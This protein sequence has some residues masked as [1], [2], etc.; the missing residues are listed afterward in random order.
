MRFRIKDDIEYDFARLCAGTL[1]EKEERALLDQIATDKPTQERWIEFCGNFTEQELLTNFH[2]IDNPT[3]WKPFTPE[4]IDTPV[5]ELTTHKKSIRWLPYI[6]YA[7]AI[8][9]S[10][11]AIKNLPRLFTPDKTSIISL[12]DSHVNPKGVVLKLA[13]GQEIDLSKSTQ[14]IALKDVQVA[15][16]D[17]I[18]SFTG[19]QSGTNTLNV[20]AGK[21]ISIK[22]NDGSLLQVNSGTTV[23]FPFTFGQSREISVTG[24]AYLNI[25]K[26][27]RRPF[28]VHTPG[29]DVQVLGTEFNLNSYDEKHTKVSLIKGS[30][31]V[32]TQTSKLV[33]KPG[34]TATINPDA[35][36]TTE[37]SQNEVVLGWKKGNYSFKN[38]DLT[39]IKTVL[40]RWYG[41]SVSIDNPKLLEQKFTGGIDKNADITVFLNNLAAVTTIKY[42]LDANTVRFN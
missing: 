19:A 24:E 14:S 13:D 10:I 26:D 8:C 28:V 38:A 35:G 12:K 1:T 25:A 22:L 27:A 17:E 36:I 4:E 40:E 3:I 31:R 16:K 5:P 34:T 20:P 39:E 42:S 29:G 18:L 21:Q 15:I 9:I 7:A 6:G 37:Q 23:K 11:I 30:V 33:L 2:K 41:V 32:V